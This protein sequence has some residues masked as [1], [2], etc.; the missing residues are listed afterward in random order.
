MTQGSMWASALRFDPPRSLSAQVELI[1]R[2]LTTAMVATALVAL[3]AAV[4]YQFT[5]GDARIWWW[6]VGTVG[7]AWAGLLA[8]R[9]LPAP[10]QA[11]F[12][13]VRHARFLLTLAALSGACWGA[14]ALLFIRPGEPD[15]ATLIICLIAGMGSAALGIF[16]SVWPVALSY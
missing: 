11:A 4:A 16:G 9:L 3:I 5:V 12:D 14:L 15:S 10:G 1:D 6:S 2:G 8:H 13:P 7:L